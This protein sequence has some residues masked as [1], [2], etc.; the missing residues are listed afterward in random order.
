MEDKDW[1][2]IPNNKRYHPANEGY[3]AV[4]VDGNGRIDARGR[5]YR[6]QKD[7]SWRRVGKD[8]QPCT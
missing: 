4:K 3:L 8:D 7:G 6:I 1:K 5:R 2:K